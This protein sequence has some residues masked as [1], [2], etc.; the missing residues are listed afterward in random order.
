MNMKR[1]QK[2]QKWGGCAAVIFLVIFI[3]LH[4]LSGVWWYQDTIWFNV[5]SYI[6]YPPGKL[7]V[8][9]LNYLRIPRLFD[10]HVPWYQD[11]FMNATWAILGMVWWFFLGSIGYIIWKWIASQLRDNH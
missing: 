6:N 3:I 5:L 9:F 7:A 1:L 8:L 11:M 2:W 4:N 10:A